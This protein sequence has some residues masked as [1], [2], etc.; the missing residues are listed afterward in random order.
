MRIKFS[1]K[2]CICLFL[3]LLLSTVVSPFVNANEDSSL[4]ISSPAALLMDSSSGKIL[5]EKNTNE[6]RYPASLTKVMT[7]IVVLEIVIWKIKQLLVMMLLCLFLLVMLQQ[8]F[9]SG[10]N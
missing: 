8:I 6:K 4:N 3:L 2:F 10:K 5:Y 9:R 1:K 7:A